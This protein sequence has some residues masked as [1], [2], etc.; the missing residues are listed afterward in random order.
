M[1]KLNPRFKTKLALV[2]SETLLGKELEDVLKGRAPQSTL[3]TFAANGEGNFAEAEGE[4]VYVEPLDAKTMREVQA[5]LLA[6]SSQGAQKAYD[7]AKAAGGTPVLIDCSG[8]LEHLPE[9]RIL[10]PLL[11]D[12][13]LR[14]GWLITVAHP[15][16]SSL[17]LILKRLSKFRGVKQMVVNIFEPASE[18]GKK[19]ISE[20][21]QQT[22][23]LLA[24]KPLT[25]EL[26]DAQLSFNLLAQY[27]EEAPVKLSATE[28]RIERHLATILATEQSALAIP[29]PSIRL[30]AAPVFHGYSMSVWAE[31]DTSVTAQE[32]GEALACSQIEVRAQDEE[33]PDNVGAASQS[34]L[35][36]GDI[37]V[38]RNNARAV[39]FWVVGDNIRLVA[40]ETADL[41]VSIGEAAG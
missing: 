14:R 25:K 34:G 9:A 4:A 16:A 3:L 38:D 21:H 13:D 41:T 17:A 1:A 18:Y 31:F 20:L 30:I 29:M 32:V 27:G 39:W 2:G 6:G 33:P 7:L 15:A 24:F 35:I 37:R 28:S 22:T 36:A 12:T 11:R 8:Y 40:D 26:F 19:G 10:A 23:N 5:V